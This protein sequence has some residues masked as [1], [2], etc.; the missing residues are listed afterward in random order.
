MLPIKLL[1]E[2]SFSIKK[3]LLKIELKD[4]ENKLALRGEFKY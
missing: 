1:A 2:I 3:K 4:A